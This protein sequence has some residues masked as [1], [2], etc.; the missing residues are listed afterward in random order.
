[1]HTAET[2]HSF[3]FE[4]AKAIDHGRVKGER[5]VKEALHSGPQTVNRY[6]SLPLQYKA[7]HI[8][9]NHMEVRQI[10]VGDR[11]AA[12]TT[13]RRTKHPHKDRASRDQ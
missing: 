4:N 13:H 11:P 3:Y 5:L 12:R 7:I 6:V 1:M 9:T 10:H 8:R 2:G